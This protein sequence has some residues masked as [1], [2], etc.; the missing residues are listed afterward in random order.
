MLQDS[1]R[2]RDAFWCDLIDRFHR[3]LRAYCRRM[4]SSDE[5]VEEVLWDI[6]QDAVALEGT[7]TTAT[8]QWPIL[9]E[10]ARR[11]CATRMRRWRREYPLEEVSAAI[12]ERLA[13]DPEGRRECGT[14]VEGLLSCLPHQQRLA[15]D[16]RYR[17]G[18]PYW[19]VAAALDTTEPTARVHAA[20][21]L[22]RLRQLT[23][24]HQALGAPS[25]SE[26]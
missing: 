1:D 19:A 16:F 8:N 22:R 18:W 23:A 15:V 12:E 3:R 21:G 4:S 6:W 9:H 25:T 24:E 14:P 20:R 11:A 26:S 7:L 2:D 10:L 13:D 17:W 5:D